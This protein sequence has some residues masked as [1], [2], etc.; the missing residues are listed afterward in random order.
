MFQLGTPVWNENAAAVFPWKNWSA[1]KHSRIYCRKTTIPN[2]WSKVL[3]P[4]YVITEKRNDL[5]ETISKVTRYHSSVFYFSLDKCHIMIWDVFAHD[6]PLIGSCEYWLLQVKH[7]N[8][9]LK[10]GL[11]LSNYEIWSG[12][13]FNVE[14]KSIILCHYPEVFYIGKLFSNKMIH[15][16]SLVDLDTSGI[17]SHIELSVYENKVRRR[18]HVPLT[19]PFLWTAFFIFLTLCVN[20][21]IGIHWIQF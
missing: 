12:G 14:K 3:A 5:N 8:N 10:P 2:F 17:V 6:L 16:Q 15:N 20:K 9:S 7:V 18:L 4:K 21:A 19:S 11:M 13:L 1:Y